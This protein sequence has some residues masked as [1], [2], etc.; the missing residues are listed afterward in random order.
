MFDLSAFVRSEVRLKLLRLF[1]KKGAT[2]AGVRELGR[3]AGANASAVSRELLNLS[4]SGFLSSSTEGNRKVYSLN[5]SCP[6][7][8]EIRSLVLKSTD[9]S[10]L[11]KSELVLIKGIELAFVFGSV[12]SERA[13]QKSD[14]DL[15]LI[16]MPDLN[17]LNRRIRSIE[18]KSGVEIDY[19]V[20]PQWEFIRK[21]KTGFL[22]N[23]L[24]SE[25]VFIMGDEDELGRIS[26]K[27][28]N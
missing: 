10:K 9:Y 25:K 21:Q 17:E 13:T 20:M 8:P 14:I 24:S 3:L 4:S 23:V 2:K 15:L 19:V 6:A 5:K 7:L 26:Q 12:A 11:L 22:R 16:G 1:L 28:V 27:R 18:T